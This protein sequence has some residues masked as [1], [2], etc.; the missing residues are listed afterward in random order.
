MIFRRLTFPAIVGAFVVLGSGMSRAETIETGPAGLMAAMKAAQ[1][2]DTIHL[3]SGQYGHVHFENLRY[4]DYVTVAS[5]DS[6]DH[7]RFDSLTV[8][9]SNYLRFDGIHVDA[10][11]D[12]SK[13]VVHITA[14]NHI[15][16]L[17]SE[18][19]GKA[20]GVV[21]IMGPK[22]GILAIDTPTDL[23]IAHTTVHNVRHG[24]AIF[25]GRRV[26]LV[27]NKLEDIGEDSIKLSAVDTVLIENTI[28]P[29]AACPGSQ[30][31]CGF[32]PGARPG[33]T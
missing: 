4:R 7:A 11:S 10:P 8:Q 9:N 6:S 24:I 23:K 1:P 25:G 15:Q 13:H 33:I 5:A 28:G 12:K 30:G 2:G 19:N 14:S 31:T 18:I 21:P 32:H 17:N 16:I 22:F 27:D 29:S 26:A 20:D 3:K